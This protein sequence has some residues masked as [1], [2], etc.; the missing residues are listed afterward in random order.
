MI[1]VQSRDVM[2]QPKSR[3]VLGH[4]WGGQEGTGGRSPNS[5][6]HLVTG[7]PAIQYGWLPK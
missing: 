3:S 7:N 5:A 6:V 4:A 1:A 2:V